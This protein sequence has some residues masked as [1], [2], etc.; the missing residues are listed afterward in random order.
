M[1]ALSHELKTAEEW[2][3]GEDYDK[4][5]SN[6]LEKYPIFGPWGP[7]QGPVLFNIFINEWEDGSKKKNHHTHIWKLVQRAMRA[8]H[9]FQKEKD[10]RSRFHMYHIIWQRKYR[11]KPRNPHVHNEEKGTMRTQYETGG[12]NIGK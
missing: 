7:L 11:Q 3:G 9:F 2:W 4:Q 1:G 6:Y 12:N 10:F 8:E 5:Q